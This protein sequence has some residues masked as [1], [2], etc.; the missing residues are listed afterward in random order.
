MGLGT[1]ALAPCV[2]GMVLLVG[3]LVAARRTMDG[4]VDGRDVARVAIAVCIAA[5]AMLVM[6]VRARHDP[7]VNQGDPS[8]WE[9]FTDVVARRQYDVAPLLPRNAPVWLQLGNLLQYA[10]VQVGL[11]LSALPTVSPW[12]AA[13][14]IAWTLLA[15]VGA[16][17][18]RRAHPRSWLAVLVLLVAGSVGVAA[19]L[20]LKAGPTI[21]W[22]ILPDSAPHEAR[23]RD[24]FFTVAWW[25]WGTWAGIGAAAI[26]RA[27]RREFI[28]ALALLPI[29]L[30]FRGVTRRREPEASL[31]R[32]L[33]L[34]LLES[35]PVNAVL[36]V[37]GDN[38]SY[39]LWYQQVVH[40][41]RRDVTTVTVPLLAATWY[42]AE[43][44][45][46]H[47]LLDEADVGR[48][49]GERETLRAIVAHAA[50][51]GRPVAVSV[52]MPRVERE[53][54]ATGGWRLTGLVWQQAAG[55]GAS[56]DSAAAAQAR[57][58]ATGVSLP[59]TGVAGGIA[60]SREP[61]ARWARRI[62]NCPAA[63]LGPALVPT[64]SAQLDSLCNVR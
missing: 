2:A 24:Y 59:D 45:R 37:R 3:A 56:I 5:S 49:R 43:L 18:H 17:A 54:V 39:P 33:G 20:N 14:G 9:R 41:V 22:G 36:F 46:R 48:W 13:A 34:A 47:A 50:L 57:R 15:V 21:G 53:A 30:N 12:R 52:A 51:Q 23:E 4:D 1:A 58:F 8:T 26:A 60:P 32:R 31:P 64:T 19:Q 35:A 44:E 55:E 6:L 61:V 10:E 28:A 40:G 63:V 38:D 16:G 27:R 62:L 29:V 7:A 42:R 11:G 25:A